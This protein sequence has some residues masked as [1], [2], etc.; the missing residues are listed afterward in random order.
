MSW[1]QK[2]LT[3][4][5]HPRPFIAPRMLARTKFDYRREVGDCLDASVVTAPV[6]WLQR[7]LPEARLAVRRRQR[8]GIVKPLDDHDLLA[9]IRKPNEFYGD[10]A[11][12]FGTVLSYCIDGNAYWLKVRNRAGRVVELW[13]IPH[14]LIEPRRPDSGDGAFLDH[15]RYSPGGGYQ[16]MR[17]EPQDV[18]HFR[19]GIN[20]HNLLKGLSPID[21]VIREIF[22]DLESSNFVSSLLRNMGVPGVVISPKGGAMPTPDDVAATKA[23]FT[24]QFGGDRRGGPLVMGAPTEVHPYGFNPQQM[25]MSEARD[26][27]E[28]RVCACLGVPAAVVGFGAGLQQTKV[29]AT[30]EE[31]RKL[32]WHNGVLPLA[33]SLADELGRSLLPDFADGDRLEAYWDTDDVLALSEDEDKQVERKLGEFKAG[34]ITL[35]DYLTET[36]RDADESHKYYLRPIAVIEVPLNQA[37]RGN[38]LDPADPTEEAEPGRAKARGTKDAKHGEGDHDRAGRRASA[39]EMKRGE[40]YVL[41]LQRQEAGLRKAFEKPLLA[42]FGK[43]RGETHRVAAEILGTGKARRCAATKAIDDE[44]LAAILEKLGI[45]AWAAELTQAYGAHYLEVAKAVQDAAERAGLGTSLP[46]PVMRAIVA[47]GG[48]R[49]GLVDLDK[50]TRQAV[51]DALAEG[52]AEGEGV[53]QLA[54]RIADYVEGGVWNEAE[55]RARIIARTETKFAQNISTIETGTAAGVEEFMVFDGRLGPGRSL[56]SH[57]ARNGSIV[58]ADEA[59]AMADA[60]HPNG[61]LSL[62]PHFDLEND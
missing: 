40:A 35:F 46:D 42:L 55:T 43:W 28:E 9:L 24:E 32:A 1:L 47:S 38:E 52:R 11:L 57:I 21:G 45:E 29:G 56:E 2:A 48:R 3:A 50:Q 30:M 54:A 4:I 36:G 14:W 26:V 20:P 58:S 8:N 59:A 31:L 6:Q 25:N 53:E 18:V 12:W 5:R 27:A 22:A 17:I 61:T 33:R 41:M 39:E 13:Y 19:H 7:S 10:I 16:A 49:A 44:L 60:E 23:W 34:A 15:Y 37:G 51:F 62:A